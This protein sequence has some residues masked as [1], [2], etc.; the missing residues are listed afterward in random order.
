[1][2]ELFSGPAVRHHGCLFNALERANKLPVYELTRNYSVNMC[3]KKIPVLLYT[4]SRDRRLHC[5]F[6]CSVMG[7]VIL[8]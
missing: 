4:N 5:W 6:S 8:H 1:M 3:A 7:M 2:T